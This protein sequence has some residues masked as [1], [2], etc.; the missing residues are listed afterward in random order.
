MNRH[1]KIRTL[2]GNIWFDGKIN[3]LMYYIRNYIFTNQECPSSD[4]EYFYSR[5]INKFIFIDNNIEISKNIDFNIYE[6]EN[7]TDIFDIFNK[8]ESIE[9]II[10]FS[11]EKIYDLNIK[12]NNAYEIKKEKKEKI[13]KEKIKKEK[14]EKE[15]ID[16]EIREKI[17]REKIDKEI[18]EKIKREKID[19]E[20][21]EIIKR[22]KIDKEIR[23]IIKREKMKRDTK[24]LR[25]K[26]I[27]DMNYYIT[28]ELF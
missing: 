5:H 15:K 23:E 4:R 3:N 21:R 22:E 12:I 6:S 24:K 13:E 17:K 8:F 26:E 20:I 18:R 16:K 10:I 14:I 11:Q 1:I 9:Y 25:Q 28:T 19:K 2:N 7:I 27:K